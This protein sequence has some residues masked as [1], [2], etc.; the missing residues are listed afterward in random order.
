MDASGRT[1]ADVKRRLAVGID[2]ALDYLHQH[3]YPHGEFCAYIS[4]D[5]A[6]QAG[7]CLPDPSLF[8]T[9]LV[10]NCL[11]YVAGEPRAEEM[12]TRAT[13]FLQYQMQ[14]GGV[15]QHFPGWH[16]F[17]AFSPPDLDDTACIS[18]LL[19]AR[20]ID[21]P[22]P[23]NIPL[24]LANRNREGLFYTWLIPRL[25]P[26]AYGPYWRLTLPQLLSVRQSVLFWRAEAARQDVDAV[27]NANV[28]YYLGERAETRAVEAYLLRIIAEGREAS[29]DKWYLNVYSVYYFFGRAYH[30]GATGL[31]PA[32]SS[33]TARICAAAQPDGR[34]GETVLDTALAACA[35]LS[36]GSYPPELAAAIEF[37]LAQQ[38]PAGEW[39]R[40]RL[41]YGG[42]KRLRGW[43][44]EELTTAFCLEALARYQ[45]LP[46]A[47]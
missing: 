20:G 16:P 39:P 35:L 30:N 33:V 40:W 44:S 31:A 22:K 15:W 41:Y 14:R 3:Q 2:R 34:L 37:L 5:E 36:W 29:C 12:L 42:R 27:V 19:Q 26:V 7:Y 24:L 23:T 38:Q 1:S 6:M 18:A 4:P 46:N 43:G 9:V 25:R 21:C 8:P 11:L 45:S 28:L 10:S 13:R 47:S 32:R 17:Y